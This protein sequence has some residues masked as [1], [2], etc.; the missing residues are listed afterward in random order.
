MDIRGNSRGDLP[1]SPS[2]TLALARNHSNPQY[3]RNL[4]M[5]PKKLLVMKVKIMTQI[6]KTQVKY[7]PFLTTLTTHSNFKF[8]MFVYVINC[9]GKP[10]KPNVLMRNAVSNIICALVFGHRFEYSNEKFQK[11]LTLLDNGTRIEA[12][13]WAQVLLLIPPINASE[14]YPDRFSSI[15]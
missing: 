10:F 8:N 11:M 14:Y 9:P 7:I 13:I 6:S 3:W 4:F 2:N 15:F 12:S 1:S 5:H